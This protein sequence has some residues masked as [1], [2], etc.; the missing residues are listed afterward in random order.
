VRV[1]LALPIAPELNEPPVL[2]ALV[3]A[4]EGVGFSSLWLSDHLLIP[5][6]DFI[7]HGHQPDPLAMLG[8]LAATTERVGI[9]TS[10]LVLPYRDPVV[11]AK[12]AGTADWLS[13]GRVTLGIGAG[14][15]QA[16]F[17]ALGIPF[18]ERGARTDA[19]LRRI[20]ACWAEADG[21]RAAP[22]GAPGHA[23]PLLV[24]GNSAPAIRR[25]AA[26]GDGWQPL[27]L[28]PA[29]LAAALPAYRDAC[30]RGP[31]RVVARLSPPALSGDA[32]SVRAELEEYGAAGADEVVVS[33]D[34]DGG[35]AATMRRVADFAAR[36][37]L[38]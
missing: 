37:G 7:P 32:A 23:I 8:W 38:S 10:V 6:G 26:L 25:A 34:E 20:R 18:A 3:R 35:P 27:N 31:G 19:A 17:A 33:L 11:V 9:G 13:G 4:A 14:W 1:G 21:M 29:E 30:E 24:G 22:A 16:E 12:A 15:L 2:R 28:T 36:A 5:P